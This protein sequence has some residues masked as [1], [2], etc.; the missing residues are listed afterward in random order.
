[1]KA[2]SQLPWQYL[3][4]A[5]FQLDKMHKIDQLWNN[6]PLFCKPNIYTYKLEIN[7]GNTPHQFQN[8]Y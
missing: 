1:M 7:M 2:N 6:Q 4:K 8:L 5:Q 3:L